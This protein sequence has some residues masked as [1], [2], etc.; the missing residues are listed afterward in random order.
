M[1][2]LGSLVVKLAL[3]HAEFTGGLDKSEQAALAASK[4]IQDTFDGMKSRIA[5]T[6]G[7]IAGGLAAGFTVAAFKNIIQGSIDTGAALDDLRQ[8]TGATVEGLSAMLAVGKFNDVGPERLGA[9]MN[10]LAS[11][12]A[13]ATEESKGTGKALEYLGINLEDFRKLKPEEQ[14]TTLA[15]SLAELPE[16][17][18]KSAVAMAI[19]GKEGAQLLPFMNDLASVGELQAKMTT[20]QAAAAANLDDNLKRLAMS[21]DGWKKELANGMIPALDLGAQAL[22]D[23]MNGTGGLREKVKGLAGDGSIKEWTHNAIIG[24]SY[25]ADVV[26]GLMSLFPIMGKAIGAAMAATSEVV[27]SVYSAF[28]K[29]RGGDLGGAMT[30]L[31]TGFS[32]VKTI[33]VEAGQDISEVWNQKLFGERLRERMAELETGTAGVGEAADKAAKPMANFVNQTDKTAKAAAEAKDPVAALLDTISKRTA[34][35]ASELAA[36]EK[37]TEGEKAS[38]EVLEQLR[39]GKVKVTQAE[40]ELIGVRLEAMLAAEQQLALHQQELKQMEAA[41][42]ER[43]KLYQAVEQGVESL[44][45]QNQSLSEEIELIGLSEEAQLAVIRGRNDRAIA[46]KQATLA[47]LELQAATTGTMTRQQI[48]LQ[49]EIDLLKERNELLGKKADVTA[50]AKAVEAQSAAWLDMWN[51]VDRTAH[52]VFVDVANNGM[53]AFKRIGKTL[54]ASV[55]DLLYQMT[56]RKWIFQ[57]LASVTGSVGATAA[58]AASAVGGAS[59]VASGMGLLGNLGSG[60]AGMVGNTVGAI[61]G[62]GVGNVALGS[63]L[64]LGASSSA[65]AASAAAAAGGASTAGISG[66]GSLFSGLGAAM[67]WLAGA[68][69]LLSI[70]SSLDDSGTYH[71]GG[72]AQYSAATGLQAG[73]SAE[74][75]GIGVGRVEAGAET[76]TA[77]SSVAQGLGSALDGLAQ[78]FGQTG[79]FRVGTS[80]ADDSSKDRAWG[81]LGIW[82]DG[83]ELANWNNNRESKWA[84]R[85]FADGPEGYKQFLAAVAKDSRDVV[86]QSIDLPRWAKDMLVALGDTPDMEAFTGAMQQIA[87]VQSTFVS[88]GES[89][90]TFATMGDEAFAAIMKLSGGIDALAANAASYYQNFYTDAER[91]AAL[92]GRLTGQLGDLGFDLPKTREEYRR[93]MEAQDLNTE[94]GR[95]AYAGLLALS[96][97]FAQLVP[98]VDAVTQSEAALRDERIANAR[99]VLKQAIDAERSALQIQQDLRREAVEAAQGVFDALASGLQ[100][101]SNQI[102]AQVQASAQAGQA[103]LLKAQLAMRAGAMPDAQELQ[104]AIGAVTAGI[105]SAVGMSAQD[106]TFERMVLSARLAEMKDVAGDQLSYEEQALAGVERQIA[107]LDDLQASFDRLIDQGGEA[108]A[109]TLSVAEAVAQLTE[110]LQPSVTSDKG[111]KP[112]NEASGFTAG[113]DG[114]GGGGSGASVSNVQ[115]IRDFLAAGGGDA[116]QIRTLAY[117]KG[118]TVAEM[119]EASSLPED[120]VRELLGLP[121]FVAGGTHTG[122]WAKVGEHGPELAY[123]PPARIYDTNTSRAMLGGSGGDSTQSSAQLARQLE[124]AVQELRKVEESTRKTA[125]LLEKFTRNGTGPALVKVAP[126]V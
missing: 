114:G 38:I 21:G 97:T 19:L 42:S 82:R 116:A 34:A 84:P 66:A 56:L 113:P 96:S 23:V 5:N 112:I 62:T 14:M 126:S 73:Q 64:G 53:S 103:Y 29:I 77:V 36:G 95:K 122:G 54:Q 46:T 55:L 123:L 7:A 12:L 11:N 111:P 79:G 106:R 70:V 40:A 15:K 125:E 51:S 10:K 90:S 13:G 47:E 24:F 25:V 92:Q 20:E 74:G 81:G 107:Q 102:P 1:S 18:N 3:Q 39:T 8:Q 109:A 118:W 63:T 91:S 26:Q 75:F 52:D 86:I 41:R 101:L 61:F 60:I 16:G 99:T 105:D 22:L 119:A 43:M 9:A 94:A 2:A 33:G 58:S 68:A 78:A 80:Y 67:P 88:L 50:A 6:A 28:Q 65:A 98:A 117:V 121:A 45:A 59:N 31:E 100:S 71:T 72:A 120:R 104:D 30:D 83:Q 110:A 48:A 17:A 87:V 69:A 85:E 27:S 37:L 108:V 76:I 35:F 115:A 93:L 89:I 124:L 57:I 44:A 32:R 4:R 49:Q